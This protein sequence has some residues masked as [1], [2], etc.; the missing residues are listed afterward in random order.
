[1]GAAGELLTK[2]LAAI[3]IDRKKHAFIT[4][5]VKCRPPDNRNPEAGEILACSDMIAR[6]I[7]IIGPKALLLLGRVAAHAL[8]GSTD[9]VAD[10]RKRNGS[11]FHKNIPAFVTYHPAALLRNDAYRRPAWEDLQKLQTILTDAGVYDV[12]A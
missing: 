12:P 6:Q 3:Q 9:S 4:N 2:M 8:L 7:D 11:L 5:I 1:V 10:L